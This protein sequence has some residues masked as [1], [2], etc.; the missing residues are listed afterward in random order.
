ML[1][2]LSIKNYAII[3]KLDVH[4]AKGFCVITGET[5][6]GKSI[7]MG[8]LGLILGQRADSAVLNNNEGKCVVEGRFSVNSNN[9]LALFFE[10]NDLDYEVPIVLRREITSSG[11]SR[12][13][14]ND[15]PV[16]LNLIRE[17]GVQLIDIH[18]QH[19]NLELGKRQF[20][21][22]VIDWYAGHETL[23]QNYAEGYKKFKKLER[24]REDIA[25]I[26]A[27]SKADLDYYEFQ[28]KQLDEASLKDGEMEELELELEVLTHSEEI[29]T[30]LN[31]VY[32]LL[33]G[34][35]YD[36]LTKLKEAVSTMQKLVVYLPNANELHKRLESQF[37]EMRDIATECEI[38]AE[39]TEHDPQRLELISDRLNFLYSLQQKHRV[40]R[41]GGLIALRNQFDDKIQQSASYD[42]ELEKLDKALLASKNDL[43]QFASILTASRVKQFPALTKE[44]AAYLQQLGMPNG[45][46]DIEINKKD[47]FSPSGI[48]EV[49][50]LFSANKGGQLEEINK[51]AS[52]GELSR[53]MLA[54]KTVV[55]KSK[56]LSA[57]IFDEIDSGISGEVAL[58]MGNILLNMSR[59]M[60][61][62]NITHLPQIASKGENHYQVYKNETIESTETGIRELANDERIIEIAK[63]LSGAN[64]NDA[65]IENAKSLM[66][67]KSF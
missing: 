58:K 8:A 53:L 29:K 25:E 45:V 32:Q 16:Q 35:E 47:D 42:D 33:D 37:L 40:D 67:S 31:K 27:Q 56:A 21:L 51:V 60:Q 43:T 17:L 14:I 59:Y 63:M 22:N 49:F 9:K 64:P 50:F 38:L 66:S 39:K 46:F 52:G 19:S 26:A 1:S 6:A 15:T 55:A 61:V 41:I 7:I 30:G 57:I 54:I 28:F 18:S 44:I 2:T 5:G 23:L 36:V 48:D 65:A 13:F 11:K 34:E 12:A 20:Q 3:K 24:Q 10:Q 62:I 4:F